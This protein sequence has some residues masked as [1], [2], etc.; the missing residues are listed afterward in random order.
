MPERGL[1]AM[2]IVP[3][4][5]MDWDGL[6]WLWCPASGALLP[7]VTR[8]PDWAVS[9]GALPARARWVTF[10]AFFYNKPYKEPRH[11]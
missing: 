10:A 9:H 2:A 11:E 1:R 7:G 5:G 8:K 6:R 4:S 3:I